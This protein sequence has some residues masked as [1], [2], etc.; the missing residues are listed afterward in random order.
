MLNA[1]RADKISN[2]L[3]AIRALSSRRRINFRLRRPAIARK[4]FSVKSDRRNAD[5]PHAWGGS[6]PQTSRAHVQRAAALGLVPREPAGHQQHAIDLVEARHAGR[7]A[8]ERFL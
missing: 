6:Q 4:G 3:A 5:T 8:G 7:A 1:T 2:R